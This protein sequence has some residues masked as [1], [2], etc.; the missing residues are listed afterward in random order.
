MTDN[1]Y[2]DPSVYAS[3]DTIC[4]LCGSESL[5]ELHGITCYA[6]PFRVD[7]CTG[8]GFIFMNPRFTDRVILDFYGEDYYSGKADYAY[9]DERRIWPYACHVWDRRIRVIR[10]YVKGGNF[11]DIGSAFGGLLS[12]ADRYYKT[13][14]IE[15][16][17]Y[18]V[19]HSA[20]NTRAVIHNGTL[21]DHPFEPDFFSVITM[22]EVIEHLPDPRFV[23]GECSRLLKK[24]GVLVI[25]TANMEGLQA[26]R[27]GE[28]YAYY[29]PGHLSYY[30]RRCLVRLL[31]ENGFSR[32]RI[33]QPVEFGLLPKLLKSRGSFRSLKDYRSWLRITGYHL[34]SKIHCGNFAATS[35]MV[36]YATK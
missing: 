36:I 13:Y 21:N 15:I 22:I 28:N 4:P 26:V 27:Q 24:G 6:K 34:L 2:N 17:P 29:M 32:V 35:S 25:Q 31:K 11:L 14:G 8:C 1:M 7:R 12:R 30:S 33:Y 23:I 19:L 3:P 10:R 5:K 16:S 18:S 20:S 9:S